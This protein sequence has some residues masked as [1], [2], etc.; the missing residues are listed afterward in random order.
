MNGEHVTVRTVLAEGDVLKIEFPK[1]HVSETLLPEPVPLDI[2]YEDDHVLVVNKQP[3]VSSIP[4]REHP[5]ESIA[6]GVISHY[7]KSGV[8]STVHLVTR[9]DRDTSGAMLIAKHR[10]SH[11]LLSAAQKRGLSAGGI[12]L[13]YT[14]SCCRRK[15]RWTRPSEEN[16]TVL[17]SGW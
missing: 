16:T 9:L 15:E 8:P 12:S 2:L 4:S 14:G 3:Y 1:E 13:S 6:N 11:S 10:L 5:S 7:R 17:L